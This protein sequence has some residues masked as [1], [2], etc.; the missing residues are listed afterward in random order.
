[1]DAIHRAH[2]A[3]VRGQ[4]ARGTVTPAMFREALASVPTRQREAWLDEVCEIEGVPDDDP[5][6]PRGCV[7][8]LPCSLATLLD[9]V[10]RADVTASDVFVDIGSGIGRATTLI[11]LLTGAGCIGI[12]VQP[13]LV[14]EARRLAARLNLPRTTA[15]EG[16]AAELTSFMTVG[17]VFFLYCPFSGDRL[18]RVLAALQSLARSR[19]LRVCCVDL[20]LPPCSWLEPVALPRGDLAIYR[21]HG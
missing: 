9:V 21:T 20:P 15:V 12:E 8:Y 10:E 7:P 1:M 2:A 17:T 18:S 19:P 11:H 4:I 6:L 5:E 16:D 14:H 13:G 3:L